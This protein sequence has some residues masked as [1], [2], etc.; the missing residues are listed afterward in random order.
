MQDLLS[1]TGLG[2][3]L[4]DQ[5][6]AMDGHL[7]QMCDFQK[8]AQIFQGQAR[9]TGENCRV[10]EWCRSQFVGSLLPAWEYFS[11]NKIVCDIARVAK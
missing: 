11:A 6:K 4:K 8:V 9:S 10:L 3:A 2:L 7:V 1:T 5:R